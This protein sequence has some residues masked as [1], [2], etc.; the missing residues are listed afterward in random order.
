M[1]ELCANVAGA[2]EDRE[3]TAAFLA[4]V[5]GSPVLGAQDGAAGVGAGEAPRPPRTSRR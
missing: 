5:A 1:T 3:R 4:G 2:A